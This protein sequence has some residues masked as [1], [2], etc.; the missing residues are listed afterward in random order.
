MPIAGFVEVVDVYSSAY[1]VV[2]CD[3]SMGGDVGG[4][5]DHDVHI[6]VKCCCDNDNNNN[7]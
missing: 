6:H 7:N 3:R 5:V 4:P 2:G 1:C